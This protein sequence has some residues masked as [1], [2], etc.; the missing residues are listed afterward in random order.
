MPH[1][2]IYTAQLRIQLPQCN[3]PLPR[4]KKRREIKK[5]IKKDIGSGAQQG[6]TA[7]VTIHLRE[8]LRSLLKDSGIRVVSMRRPLMEPPEPSLAPLLLLN[9][10]SA[11][12][13]AGYSAI[14]SL[15]IPP[16]AGVSASVVFLLVDTL[17]LALC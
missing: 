15:L 1:L 12:D 3:P 11:V 17:I 7:H 2:Q 4:L 14:G 9:G 5:K 8:L 16:V 6:N 13:S 10:S